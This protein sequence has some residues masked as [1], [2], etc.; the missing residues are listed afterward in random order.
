MDSS[1]SLHPPGS[2]IY[3]ISQARILEWVAI[4]FSRGSSRSR[5]WTCISCISR[6]ILYHW[7]TWEVHQ[8]S[9]VQL[10]SHIYLFATLWTAASQACLSITNSFPGAYSNSCP[11]SQWCHPT[12]S[13][14]VI[15]F[16]S[17]PQSFPASGSFQ[18][19][20][21]SSGGQ[22][23]G[24]S[25]PASVL[26]MNIQDWFPLGLTGLI[27]LLSKGHSRVFPTPQF[28]SIN[29]LALSFLYSPTLKSTFDY[30]KNHSFD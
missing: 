4:S 14:S 6:W 12:V 8:F 30:W 28:K 10:L 15:P 25:S 3:G 17:C 1:A 18:M 20:Q 27:F 13:S 23:I 29:S 2:A 24:V 21:F 5:D 11:S 22:S 9:S 7:A 26:P 16:S 19:S